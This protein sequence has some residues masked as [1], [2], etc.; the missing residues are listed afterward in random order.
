MTPF[1]CGWLDELAP[2]AL[3]ACIEAFARGNSALL[4]WGILENE[5]RLSHFLAQI[6]HE[7][8]G[9]RH[10]EENLDYSPERLTAVWPNRF[11][12]IGY[13]KQYSRN[14]EK[15]GNYVY[16]GRLG[17]V[18]VDDGY[19]FRGRGLIQMTGRTNYVRIGAMLGADL[20]TD[21]DRAASAPYMVVI[22]AAIWRSSGC[23]EAADENN[24]RRVTKLINGGYVGLL[25][26]I[27]WHTRVRE[28]M[29]LPPTDGYVNA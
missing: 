29:G 9:L 2:Q 16:G 22:A 23:N 10:I 21:P 7:S 14:P 3:P 4:P 28:V 25:S 5:L 8:D 17:N 27:H 26:R 12:S 6:L 15:L 13:A 20:I 1:D 11:L 24:I 19:R 18:L